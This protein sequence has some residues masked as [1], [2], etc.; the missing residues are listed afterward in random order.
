MGNKKSSP[1]KENNKSWGW[2]DA[3]VVKSTGYSSKGPKFNFQY[4]YQLTFACKF[5]DFNS[6]ISDTLTQTHLQIKH[7]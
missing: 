3:S 7:Q 6:R 5:N 1:L 4:T 2:R